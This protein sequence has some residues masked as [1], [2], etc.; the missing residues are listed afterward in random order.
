MM[1]VMAITSRP[2]GVAPVGG[3]RRIASDSELRE[4]AAAGAGFVIDPSGRRWH[5]AVCPRVAAMTTG[6]PKW[7]AGTSAAREAFLEQRHARHATAQ[8]VL[9]CPACGGNAMLL[10]EV[11]SR[12]ADAAGPQPAGPFMRRADGGFEVWAAQYVRNNSAS[13]SAAGLLRQLIASG[14]RA[15]PAPAGRVLHAGYAGQRWPGNDVENLLFNNIE[16]ELA[17]FR[18]AGAQGV[19]FEDMGMAVPPPPDGTTWQSYYRYRLA[20]PDALFASV[21]PGRLLCRVREAVIPDGPARLAARV[22]LA[23]R[24]ARPLPEAGVPVEHGSFM[25]RIAVHQLHPAESI[26][27]VVDGATAAMQRDDP[28]RVNEAVTRLAGLLHADA[29][30]LLAFATTADAPLGARSRPGPAF[31][32]S[33]FTLDGPT[34]VRVTPDDD[35]CI[36]AEAITAGNDGLARLSVEVYSATRHIARLRPGY[37][38]HG[39]EYL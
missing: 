4:I 37:L 2:G 1:A 38:D 7:H 36:A 6:Q 13:A 26:K 32:Q 14:I 34:Q 5:A 17:L 20:H 16:Q 24:R 25:L 35:R 30:E 18:H 22:W 31:R 12:P 29:A 8:P 33:L 19:R 27:A 3:A 23:V 9:P 21:K 39:D 28:E 15:L 11:A 10:P